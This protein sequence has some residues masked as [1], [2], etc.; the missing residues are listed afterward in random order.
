[1]K[2]EKKTLHVNPVGENWEVESENKTLG[3]AETQPEAVELAQELAMA[4]QAATIEVHGEDGTL[5]KEVA[6]TSAGPGNPAG[7]P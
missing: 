5:A 6:V 4:E 1:M 7:H 3:Q 2:A